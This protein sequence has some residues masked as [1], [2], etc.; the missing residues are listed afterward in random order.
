M[1]ITSLAC[2]SGDTLWIGVRN[3]NFYLKLTPVNGSFSIK[4]IFFNWKIYVGLK[5]NSFFYS[6]NPQAENTDLVVQGK[7]YNFSISVNEPLKTLTAAIKRNHLLIG[8]NNLVIDGDNLNQHTLYDNINQLYIDEQYNTWILFEHLGFGRCKYIANLSD[9]EILIRNT[10]FLCFYRDYEGGIWLGSY[11]KGLFYIPDIRVSLLNKKNGLKDEHITAITYNQDKIYVGTISGQVYELINNNSFRHLYNLNFL[12]TTQNQ[13]NTIWFDNQQNMW[14]GTMHGV[15]LVQKDKNSIIK[16]YNEGRV[17]NNVKSFAQ[18]GNK[19][20]IA[21]EGSLGYVLLETEK[22]VYQETPIHFKINALI[23]DNNDELWLGTQSGLWKYNQR[24]FNYFGYKN[25]SLKGIINSLTFDKSHQ[26]WIATQKN[27]VFCL[28]NNYV[29]HFTTH[30]GLS[31]NEV[32]NIYINK[33]GLPIAVIPGKGLNVINEYNRI[34]EY[35]VKNS[36]PTNTIN[37]VLECNNL[38]YCASDKGLILFKEYETKQKIKIPKTY[39]YQVKVNETPI[40][41]SSL[42]NIKLKPHQNNIDVYFK[43][44]SFK[45]Q[46]KTLYRYR[47]LGIHDQ[48]QYTQE[49]ELRFL[50]LNDGEYHL[51]IQAQNCEGKWGNDASQLTFSIA[52]PFYERAWFIISAIILIATTSGKIVNIQLRKKHYKEIQQE[53]L[54]RRLIDLELQALRAQMNPHFIFNAINSIQLFIINNEA[55]EAQKYLSKFAKLMRNVLD[56]SKTSHISLEKEIQTIQLYMDLESLRFEDHFEYTITI[57]PTIN[58]SYTEIPSMLIQP[59]VENAIWHGLMHKQGKGL[60]TINIT[61]ITENLIKCTVEDNGI[62]RKKAE[63]YK[64]KNKIAH[65]SFGM[66]IT[67]ERLQI[68]NQ[69]QA[70]NL[71]VEVTDLYNSLNEAIG[72]KVDIYIPIN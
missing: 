38:L 63:E 35:T 59:F 70:S 60:I 68:L 15:F 39:I 13:I 1:Q 64:S 65:K 50:N 7:G 42:K 46:G 33:K 22:I 25:K 31:D 14:I 45:N 47:L 29:K 16:I 9:I 28:K 4:K 11:D 27:G 48:W 2:D 62:G 57:D 20:W 51:Q 55:S 52:A 5:G 32:K 44:I 40:N 58:G 36:L 17:I 24:F 66:M 6:Y 69:R 61:K 3:A 71:T 23:A 53:R 26:L 67:K 8:F 49:T 30:N 72:T 34:T 18:I 41:F 19:V 12:S 56:N 37:Q 54:K 43:S 10:D 21:A